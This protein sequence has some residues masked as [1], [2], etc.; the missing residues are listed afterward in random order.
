MDQIFNELSVSTCY[1]DKY[2]ARPGMEM[3]IEVSLALVEEGMSKTIRTTRD[4]NT[5][6]LADNYTVANWTTDKEVNKEIKLYFLTHATKSPYID[7][8]WEQHEDQGEN[9]VEYYFDGEKALGLGL[10][11]LWDIFSISLVGDNRFSEI[12]IILSEYLLT[13]ENEE[14]RSITV[15]TFS[16]P[17]HVERNKDAIHEGLRNNIHCGL[18][19]IEKAEE[20]L[21]YLSFCPNAVDQIY[22]LRGSEEFFFEA[23][24]HL[25]IL[26]ETMRE[27]DGGDFSPELNFSSESKSTMSNKKFI[28]KRTFRCSDDVKRTFT[29]HSKIMSENKRIY[30]FPIPED[31]IV[32]IGHVG[33]H[34]PTTKFKK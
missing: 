1:S 31:K 3:A 12:D 14:S 4:F 33:D 19:L 17:E 21:T 27:W 32:H 9:L 16:T 5:R 10:A 6:F 29:L 13:G 22:S 23:T 24:R 25:F 26:N 8:F 34:L 30:F 28:Q 11:H 20:M 18:D 7:N 2:A 15:S